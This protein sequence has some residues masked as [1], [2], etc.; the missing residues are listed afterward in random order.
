MPV[1][2][3]SLDFERADQRERLTGTVPPAGRALVDRPDPGGE[4]RRG[5]EAPP[6]LLP[7]RLGWV[8]GSPSRGW[9]PSPTD[10]TLV[11]H[12]VGSYNISYICAVRR[13]YAWL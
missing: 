3:A 10:R 11:V 7:E 9:T 1:R 5:G 4:H 2:H 12:G 13:P 8:G 6:S